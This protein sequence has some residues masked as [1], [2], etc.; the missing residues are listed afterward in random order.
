MW[1]E[2]DKTRHNVWCLSLRKAVSARRGLGFELTEEMQREQKLDVRVYIHADRNNRQATRNTEPYRD[3]IIQSLLNAHLTT[4]TE[5]VERLRV[6]AEPQ[7]KP[8]NRCGTTVE[9][10]WR[11]S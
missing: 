8:E 3:C 11:D 6:I 4:S 2:L 9:V 5:N 1:G 7:S 10:T